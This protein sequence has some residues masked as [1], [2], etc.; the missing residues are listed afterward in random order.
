M[1]LA[2][3]SKNTFSMLKTVEE[4]G[5][6]QVVIYYTKYITVQINLN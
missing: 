4:I 6:Y 2:E 3:N 5:T 1:P